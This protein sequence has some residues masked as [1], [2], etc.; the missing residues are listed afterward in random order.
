MLS[1]SVRF[2]LFH[3]I[4]GL[5]GKSGNSSDE[6]EN[7]SRINFLELRYLLLNVFSFI[8]HYYIFIY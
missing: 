5:F 1:F 6:M 3:N 4:V 7:M 8:Y 2:R